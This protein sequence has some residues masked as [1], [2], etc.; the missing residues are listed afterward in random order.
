[1]AYPI[2]AAEAWLRLLVAALDRVPARVARNVVVDDVERQMPGDLINNDAFFEVFRT[3]EVPRGT[4]CG[5]TA[6]YQPDGASAADEVLV[7]WCKRDG[8]PR[9]WWSPSRSVAPIREHAQT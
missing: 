5:S 6:R 3:T 8:P 2:R 7:L 1:M 4:G 9:V